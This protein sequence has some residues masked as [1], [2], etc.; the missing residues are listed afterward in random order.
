[1]ELT[2][3]LGP[4]CVASNIHTAFSLNTLQV[5]SWCLNSP[6]QK[7]FSLNSFSSCRYRECS[8]C[9]CLS[10][11][12]VY[13]YMKSRSMPCLIL[14]ESPLTDRKLKQIHTYTHPYKHSIRTHCP[15]LCTK[16]FV[17]ELLWFMIMAN[18]VK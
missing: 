10:F 12:L 18:M 11:S 4:I 9:F 15:C 8:L 2:Q 14:M 1:M 16:A 5:S 17:T 13:W 3:L 6:S 7:G